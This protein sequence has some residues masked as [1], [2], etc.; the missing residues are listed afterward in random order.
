MPQSCKA[1]G[2]KLRDLKLPG[3]A[4]VLMID[5]LNDG[6]RAPNGDTVVPAGATVVLIVPSGDRRVN[7]MF[8]D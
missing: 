3:K 5:G 6:E 7:R 4:L 1:V 8:A 2:R